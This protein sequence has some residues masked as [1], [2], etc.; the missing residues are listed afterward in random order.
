MFDT[1]Y[2]VYSIHN[3]LYYVHEV[4]LIPELFYQGSIRNHKEEKTPFSNIKSESFFKT[5]DS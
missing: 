2:E 3:K 4:K 5:F 1:I